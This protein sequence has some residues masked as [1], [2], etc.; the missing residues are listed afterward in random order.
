MAQTKIGSSKQD[1]LDLVYISL[2]MVPAVLLS[3][4][5]VDIK[6][7]GRK[8]SLVLAYLITAGAMIAIYFLEST[9][10]ILLIA[11]CKF[12]VRLQF[13]YCYMYTAE[14]YGTKIRVTGTGFCCGISRI[15]GMILPYATIPIA[16]HNPFL[17]YLVLG[18]FSLLGGLAC[19]FM[20]YETMGEDLDIVEQQQTAVNPSGWERS[21]NG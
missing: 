16:K 21:A 11:F 4:Y 2:S 19:W 13:T 3:S 18:G 1:F 17:P 7:L 10:F 14:M 20:P 15:S 5:S 6:G 8:Y 12:A 9:Q